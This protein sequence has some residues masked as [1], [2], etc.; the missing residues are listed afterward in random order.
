MKLSV[1]AGAITDVEH[2]GDD[3]EITGIAYD[4]RSA[5]PGTLFVAL[6]G[7]HTDGHAYISAA[8]GQGTEAVVVEHGYAGDLKGIPHLVVADSR[9]AMAAL[10][11]ALYGNPSLQLTTFGVTGTNGKTS[12]TYMLDSIFKSLGDRTGIVG[13]LGAIVDGEEIPQVR[14]TPESPDLQ[15]LLR[16]MVDASITKVVMEVSSEGALAERTTGVAFDVG[17][18]TNLTPDHLNNHGTMENYFGQKIR[19]FTEYPE[20]FPQKKF[21]A[22]VNRDDPYGQRILETLEAAGRPS[23]SFSLNPGAD[24]SAEVHQLT[25]TGTHLTLLVKGHDP[26]EVDLPMAGLFSVS[27][28][29]AAAGAAVALGI[30]PAEIKAGLE[31][32]R[33]VPGRFEKIET[34]ELGFQ[35]VVDYAHSSDGLEHVLASARALNPQRLVCIF[36]CGGDRDRTK[37]P[38]MGKIAADLAD[39]V[40]VTSDNPR[41]EDPKAIVEEIVAGIDGGRA[42]PNLIVEVDRGVAIK[43]TITELAKPGDLIVIAGKGHEPYQILADRTIHFDDREQAREAIALCS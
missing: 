17:V 16:R 35:V 6:R 21:T 33:A 11:A 34:G 13:T 2:V 29:L 37:R 38:V 28:A 10:S 3:P 24:I 8:R 41:S 18:F 5:G 32:L 7:Q 1:L 4:S 25:V 30:S 15:Q 31:K 26:V 20:A 23:I 14:T 12:T 27:N 19:L 22:V 39:V 42:R 36:G 40:V 43:Q 9:K